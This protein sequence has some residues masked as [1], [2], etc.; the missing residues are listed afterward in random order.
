[1]P[2]FFSFNEDEFNELEVDEASEYEDENEDNPE[3]LELEYD[4]EEY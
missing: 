3:E 1:M 4:E 2:N